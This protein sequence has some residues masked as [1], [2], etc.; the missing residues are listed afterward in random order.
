MNS[1]QFQ[2]NKIKRLINTQGVE[3]T[4]TRPV[5]NEFQEPN[6]TTESFTIKG[7]YHE[8]TSYISKTSSD[9]STVRQ[10]PSPM[11]LTLW[12]SAAVLQHTDRLSYNGKQYKINGIKDVAESNV[13]ADI[14]LEEIQYEL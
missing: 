12:S 3:F 13:A 1:A 10:K 2:L 8:I 7:V 6:G 9:A 4:F 14:S 11:I 5:R